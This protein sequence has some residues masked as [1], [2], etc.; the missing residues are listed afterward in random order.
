MATNG[1]ILVTG[2]AGVQAGPRRACGTGSDHSRLG[3]VCRAS[4]SHG[5][6]ALAGASLGYTQRVHSTESRLR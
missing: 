2:A 5:A 4:A 3:R 1:L 6:S